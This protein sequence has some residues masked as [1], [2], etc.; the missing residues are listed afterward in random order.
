MRWFRTGGAASSGKGESGVSGVTAGASASDGDAHEGSGVSVP[1]VRTRLRTATGTACALALLVALTACLA[2]AFPRAVDRYE[3]SGLR[4]AAEQARPDRTGIEVY[5]PPPS[6]METTRFRE[7]ALRPDMLAEQDTE[8]RAQVPDP[9]VLDRDQSTYGVRTTQDIPV[10]DPWLPR[11]TG[12]PARVT[13]VAQTGLAAHSSLA[14]GRLPRADGQVASTTR[15]LEAA[16]SA[17]TAKALHI[18]VGSVLHVPPYTVR[19][20]GIVTPREPRGAYWS[21]KTIL[22]TP[23]LIREPLPSIA[24]Y[25]VG[26]LLLYPDA[27]PALLADSGKPERYWQLAPDI[28]ALRARDIPALRSAIASLEAGPALREVRREIDG[29]STELSELNGSTEVTTDLDEVLISYGRLRE[30][31]APLVAVAAFG[32]GTVAAVVLMM[33]GGL[34]AERR[35]SELAL[36]RARGASLRGLTARLFA[37]TAAVAVPAGALG[38]AAALLAIPAGRAGAAVWAAVAVTAVTCAALPLRAA[39]AHR[40]VRVHTGREDV[41][42]VRPSRRRTVAELTLLVLAAGA[43]ES[44]RRRGTSGS[45]GDLVSLAPV[46]L[47]VIAAL[48]LVRLYP[49]PLRG[50]ARPAA[51][52]RG[53]VAHLSLARAGRT[54]ASAVLPLLALLTALTTAAFGGS[55]LAG[56][57]EARDH[58]ALLSVGADARVES[59]APLPSGLPD[60]LRRSPGVSEVSTLSVTFEAKPA[61]G[62]QTVPLVGVDPADYAALS[63]RTGL[64]AF[65]RGE[66]QAAA[67]GAPAPALASTATARTYGTRPFPVLLPD[68]ST[69]TVRITAVLDRTPAV[70]GPDFLIVNRTALGPA[71]ARPT[72]LLLTGENLD[73]TALREAA[74]KTATVRLR[75]E[76]RAGYVDSPLQTG[77]ERVYTTAVAAGTGYTVLAL[78]LSLL[79]TAPE[80]TALLARLRTMGLTRAAGRRLLILESLPQAVLAAL[81]GVLTGWATIRLLSPGIDLTALA[82]PTAEPGAGAVELRMDL[83]SL[84]IPAAAVLLLAVGVGVGQAWWSGRRGSVTELRAGDAR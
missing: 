15:E 29:P 60:R 69:L 83:P 61:D 81:G 27:A 22:R 21:T 66:L 18:K 49:L 33:A 5:A 58:A 71:A 70:S 47:G 43:V 62:A 7:D 54:S 17:E 57:R 41:A 40:L 50:L 10:L 14:Q 56:V 63:A 8:V 3:D 11:P 73:G 72:G 76:E 46:L 26:A 53:A 64:G 31:V 2:A 75:S 35:R 80:R 45:A 77:A 1:W 48:V 23:A 42:S 12:D 30:S 65:P 59:A 34:T 9:L 38:L 68:G 52:L 82:L 16:V 44:L 20:T 13:L 84:A 4:R 25:W 36:L 67:A 37:E 19:I 39:A 28:G 74:P 79:R 55:V 78:L 32:T 6:L 24:M 51:R